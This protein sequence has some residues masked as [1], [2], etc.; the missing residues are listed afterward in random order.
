[1]SDRIIP[2][3]I[4]MLLEVENKT[5]CSVNDF[6]IVEK[7]LKNLKS[8]GLHSFASLQRADG[9]Y[10]QVAGG[11]VTCIVEWRDIR[12][13]QHWRAWLPTPRVAYTGQQTLMFGGG[14][15]TMQPDE[16]LFIDDVIVTFQAFF[17]SCP[18]PSY[19]EWRNMNYLF[20]DT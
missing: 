9:S 3:T 7:H 19:I 17:E 2:A 5:P 12:T 20:A 15:M 1:M 6:K 14:D 4:T 18:F 8:Y 11:R 16:I 13:G 10:I